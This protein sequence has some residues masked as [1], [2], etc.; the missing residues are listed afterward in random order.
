MASNLSD[1]A[2]AFL[3]KYKMPGG[4]MN[5]TPPQELAD[6]QANINEYVNAT[7]PPAAVPAPAPMRFAPPVDLL[8][9]GANAQYGAQPGEQRFDV[10]SFQKPLPSQQGFAKIGQ[11]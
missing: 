5:D 4:Q 11:K 6:K 7:K 3:S 10:S 2:K 1:K 8:N 9:Q